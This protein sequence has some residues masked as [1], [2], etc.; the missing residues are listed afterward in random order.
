MTAP[1]QLI[2]MDMTTFTPLVCRC[3]IYHVTITSYKTLAAELKAEE[4]AGAVA[5]GSESVGAAATGGKSAGAVATSCEFA[6][7]SATSV[8]WFVLSTSVVGAFALDSLRERADSFR[9]RGG[10]RST[11]V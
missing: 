6:V 1:K 3:M 8:A 5:T 4:S 10:I 2:A 7:A 9:W 11:T